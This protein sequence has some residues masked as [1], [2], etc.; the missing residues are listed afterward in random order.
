MFRDNGPRA[1]MSGKKLKVLL[2]E[3]D[4]ATGILAKMNLEKLGLEVEM[5][6]NGKEALDMWRAHGH[7]AVLLDFNMPRMSGLDVARAIRQDEEKN[8]AGYTRIIL[9][10]AK[11]LDHLAATQTRGV[12]NMMI[13]KPVDY[14]EVYNKLEDLFFGRGAV[15]PKNE[16]GGD[17][18][19][20]DDTMNPPLDLQE[21]EESVGADG[22]ADILSIFIRQADEYVLE[23]EKALGQGDGLRVSQLAHKLKGS[24]AQFTARAMVEPAEY[25]QKNCDEKTVGDDAPRM[26]EI[27]KRE[28][29][30]VK[31]YA[32][33][34]VGL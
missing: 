32:R 5:A 20:T 13:S 8:S 30:A 34:Q 17:D 9:I 15:A 4:P 25:L 16:S 27:L 29:A 1:K 11:P 24:S 14:A 12:V 28:L 10:T 22:L 21:L 2:A 3:D 6:T 7:R 33:E 23:I 31:Q 19:D 18:D 26:L